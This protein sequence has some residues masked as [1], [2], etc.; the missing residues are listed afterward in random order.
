MTR[1]A[2]ALTLLACLAS[3]AHAQRV[4]VLAPRVEAPLPAADREA[5]TAALARALQAAG[6]EVL[7]PAPEAAPGDECV[8]DAC[9][10]SR[11]RAAGVDAAARLTIWKGADGGVSGVSVTLLS[12]DGVRYSEGATPAIGESLAAAVGRA[13]QGAQ[14]RMG[15]GPGPWLEI[16]GTPEGAFI[17]V[18]GKRRGRVPDRLRVPAGLHHVVV[19]EHGYASHDTT[20]RVPANVDALE[21]LQVAL[22]PAPVSDA[23][24]AGSVAPDATTVDA[25]TEGTDR[26]SPWNYA[27]A[28]AAVGLG[29]LLA[30]GPVRSA[31]DDGQCARVQDGRCVA[32]VAFDTGSALQLGASALLVGAG[33][34]FA[35]LAPLRLQVGPESASLLLD[36]RF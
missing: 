28:A 36:T 9:A 25:A 30:V 31:I 16:T 27:I 6:L 35:A 5:L 13:A 17:R 32:V 19:E 14:E 12:A 4:V 1:T 18:D 24:A 8:E 2:L 33:V 15:R 23:P 26:A 21:R 20:V 11:I 22:S 3:G 10:L 29:G 7:E 34:T